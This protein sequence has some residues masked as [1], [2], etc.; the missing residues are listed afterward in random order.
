[1]NTTIPLLRKIRFQKSNKEN[2]IELYNEATEDYEFWSKDFNMHFGYYIPFKTTLFKRDTMLNE[3]NNQ[4]TKIPSTT[5][6]GCD[7]FF[8]SSKRRK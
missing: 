7:T 4:F 3:M 1:M 2:L 8:F 5:Y 6:F